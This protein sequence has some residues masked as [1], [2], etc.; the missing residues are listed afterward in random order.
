ME[1]RETVKKASLARV[2]A[3]PPLRFNDLLLCQ[4]LLLISLSCGLLLLSSCGPTS[5]AGLKPPPTGIAPVIQS[6]SFS[7]GSDPCKPDGEISLEW[8][9]IAPP[10][11]IEV[12]LDAPAEDPAQVTTREDSAS[13]RIKLPPGMSASDSLSAKISL[14]DARGLTRKRDLQIRSDSIIQAPPVIESISIEGP[15]VSVAVRGSACGDM[16]VTVDTTTGGLSAFPQQVEIDSETGVAVFDF[17]APGLALAALGTATFRVEDGIGQSSTATSELIEVPAAELAPGSLYAIPLANHAS[18]GDVVKVLVYSGPLEFS[19]QSLGGVSLV[20]P[21]GCE[22]D[23]ASLD[24]GA[25]AADDPALNPVAPADRAS[26]DGIWTQYIELNG[27]QVQSDPIAEADCELPEPF[28]DACAWQFHVTPGGGQYIPAGG[29]G[30]LFSVNLRF[31]APG[32][33][34]LDLR[35]AGEIPYCWYSD[36]DG[37]THQWSDI[38]NAIDQAVIEVSAAAE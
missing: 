13:V 23:P 38:S 21:P 8:Y 10:Y 32:S 30:A 25:P 4:Q 28:I 5:Q 33:Y 26:A 17:S 18:V 14:T 6:V 9:G 7:G 19:L 24:F 27:F 35:P 16:T 15:S 1:R 37:A 34:R 29:Q 2:A 22:I 12:D 36:P 3:R 31:T 11:R 20:C